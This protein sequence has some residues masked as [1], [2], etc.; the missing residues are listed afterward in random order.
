[1]A[2]ET[3]VR[4]SR[5]GIRWTPRRS[6]DPFRTILS[7]PSRNVPQLKRANFA[8][9]GLNPPEQVHGFR[10]LADSLAETPRKLLRVQQ[11][12]GGQA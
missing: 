10:I 7:V 2:E 4:A 6:A 12:L 11:R 1:M 5:L 8:T 3:C 9:H